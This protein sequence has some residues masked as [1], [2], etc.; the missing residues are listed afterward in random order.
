MIWKN[1]FLC[2]LD[3]H[4][5][6]YAFKY[7]VQNLR[8]QGQYHDRETG[9]HYNTFR[10]Y[11][12][13]TGRFTTEDPIGLLGGLNLYQYA[14]N[15]LMWIDPWGWAKMKTDGA[16]K[17]GRRSSVEEDSRQWMEHPDGHP[18]TAGDATHHQSRHVHATNAKGQEIIVT[19]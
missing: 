4:I 2:H 9:L 7:D 6:G 15:P 10:Y 16:T 5:I 18:S 11:D 12:C 3:E 19:Y 13:D 14:P 8:M 17:L 1:I